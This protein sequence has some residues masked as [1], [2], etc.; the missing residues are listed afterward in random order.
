MGKY[1]NGQHAE[2]QEVLADKVM[3]SLSL[4]LLVSHQ[5]SIITVGRSQCA[6]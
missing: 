2:S 1:I 5:R 6:L 4:M 3:F